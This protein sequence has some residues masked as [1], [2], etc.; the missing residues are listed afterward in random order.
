[1][2]YKNTYNDQFSYVYD[3]F[4]ENMY[5]FVFS[6]FIL[7]IPGNRG[8]Y[9]TFSDREPINREICNIWTQNF[10]ETCVISTN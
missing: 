4:R 1:M 5:F 10:V 8:F 7:E 9:L 3:H 6:D 2:V